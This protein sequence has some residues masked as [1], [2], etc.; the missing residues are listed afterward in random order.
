MQ[1]MQSSWVSGCTL[2]TESYA[3][4]ASGP[5]SHVDKNKPSGQEVPEFRPH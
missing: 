3:F 4:Q 2:R 1:E 5:N